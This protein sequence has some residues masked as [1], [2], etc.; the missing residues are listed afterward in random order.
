MQEIRNIRIDERLIHGQVATV[1]LRKLK[2]DRCIVIDDKTAQNDL[3]KGLLR[4]AAP[5]NVKV[6]IL[7]VEKAVANLQAQKYDGQSIM[8]VVRTVETLV[9]M[10]NAGYHFETFN[11]GNISG[12]MRTPPTVQPVQKIKKSVFLSKEDTQD[13][14]YLSDKGV[15]ITALMVPDEDAIDFMAEVRKLKF[16]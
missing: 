4:M 7:S 2:V 3:E 10:Y 14:L 1:W 12:T 15:K 16:D 5:D 6:S 11:V 8:I 9:R 13:L